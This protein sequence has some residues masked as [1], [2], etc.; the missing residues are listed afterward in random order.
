MLDAGSEDRLSSWSCPSQCGHIPEPPHILG[1]KGTQA[2]AVSLTVELRRSNEVVNE[3]HIVN[4]KVVDAIIII[5]SCASAK[6]LIT[7]TVQCEIAAPQPHQLCLLPHWSC[8]FYPF[9]S[10]LPILFLLLL[11]PTCP[12]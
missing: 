6:T 9:Y 8:P 7:Q 12:D 11:H 5:A 10:I 1:M 3:K 2:E 4:C